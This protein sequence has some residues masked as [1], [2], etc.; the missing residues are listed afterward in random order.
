MAM[1]ILIRA[2]GESD[3][4]RARPANQD[5]FAFDLDRGLFVVCDGVGG[6]RAGAVASRMAADYMLECFAVCRDRNAGAAALHRVIHHI[7]RK[8]RG[9]GEAEAVYAGM[10]T[11]IVSAYFDGRRMWIAHVGDSRAYLLRN[12]SLHRLTDDHSV[13]S[14]R[15]RNGDLRTNP[16]EASRLHGL[17]TQAL[18]SG[19]LVVPDVT[20]LLVSPGDRFLLATDGLT[21]SLSHSQMLSLMVASLSPQQA[22]RQ[23]VA[24]ANAAGGYDNITSIVVQ[25]D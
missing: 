13:L 5:A 9:A 23:L 16:A 12:D 11:T 18:G 4:G 17:L 15:L 8:L 19:D 25:I 6:E 24:A 14:Q 2:A 22:C 21:G 1:D 20:T 3:P 7:H 10:S